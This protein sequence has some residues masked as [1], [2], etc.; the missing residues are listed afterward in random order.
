M[1]EVFMRSAPMC[2][3]I[4]NEYVHVGWRKFE[5]QKYIHV[6]NVI[7]KLV[8]GSTV[9]LPCTAIIAPTVP[10]E[11]VAIAAIMSILL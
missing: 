2:I 7:L 1:T 11:E 5:I 6:T 3:Q 10:A 8:A 9:L 4:R